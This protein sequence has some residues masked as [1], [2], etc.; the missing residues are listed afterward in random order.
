[1]EDTNNIFEAEDLFV[2]TTTEDTTEESGAPDEQQTDTTTADSMEIEK[3]ETTSKAEPLV[4]RYNHEEKQLDADAVQKVAEAIGIDANALIANLQKGMNYEKAL[5][6]ANNN[7]SSQLVNK[8]AGMRGVD[9]KEVIE[10]LLRAEDAMMLRRVMDDVR[11]THPDAS[12]EVVQELARYQMATQKSETELKRKTEADAEQEKEKG[13]WTALFKEFPDINIDKLPDSVRNCRA[14]DMTPVEAYLRHQLA[15]Q[16][17]AMDEREK[18]AAVDAKKKEAA[19]KSPG[20][21]SATAEESAD[22]FLEGF[23]SIYK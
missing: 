4:F 12:D 17:A 18:A 9:E 1:M 22:L 14:N 16:K 15:E 23:N 11:K 10:S 2:D 3:D 19:K 6:R 7:P 5:E 21:M 8:I 20:S 13:L